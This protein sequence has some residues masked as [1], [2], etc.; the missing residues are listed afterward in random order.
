MC[1]R[2]LLAPMLAFVALFGIGTGHAAPQLGASIDQINAP[3]HS[4][5]QLDEYLNALESTSPLKALSAPAL[6]KFVSSLRF[7]E[8]GL[9]SYRYSDIESELTAQQAYRLLALFGAQRTLGLMSN[10]RMQSPEDERVIRRVLEI[11][12]ADHVGYECA[13]RA[14]CMRS[15]DRVCMGGC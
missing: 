1:C 15:P 10:I 12:A 2:H 5:A 4:S 14:T 6:E 3:I 7:N 11:P 13:G 8:S 9:V